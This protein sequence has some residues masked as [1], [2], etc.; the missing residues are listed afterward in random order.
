MAD[1]NS[2]RALDRVE[3]RLRQHR[4][5]V[6]EPFVIVEGPDDKLVLRE[7]I[8]DSTIFPAGGRVNVLRAARTLADWGIH[9]V[10]GVIDLDFD[11]P[12]DL[13][14][15]E[16]L[17]Y[18]YTQR[19]LEG[20]LISLG[21][22]A[23]VIEHLGSAKK[24]EAYGGPNL[25]VQRLIEE[26]GP[27]TK[28]RHLNARKGWSLAF[29]Q[30]KLSDKLVQATLKLKFDSY[31]A[32]LWQASDCEVGQ[33]SLVSAVEGELVDVALDPRG[34]DVLDAVGVA[35]RRVVGSLQAA[36]ATGELL[37]KHLHCSAGLALAGSEWLEGLNHRLAAM[38][39]AL[40]E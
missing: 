36:A 16:N 39:K 31:C 10:I 12:A 2:L 4:Q 34:K 25:L 9:A 22:L 1:G 29:D 14:E 8:Q 13:K 7:H 24:L 40:N 20:M 17:I 26:V 27:V 15:V 38:S 3:D 33:A 37:T 11:E 32:A 21:V 6:K 28:L 30:V 35:L 5:V 23:T 18:P 19:D